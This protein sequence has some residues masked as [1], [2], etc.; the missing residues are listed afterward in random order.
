MER[1]VVGIDGS[2]GSRAALRWGAGEAAHHGVPL[3]AVESWEFSPLVVVTEAPVQLDDLRASV[4][5]HLA[6]VVAEELG[7]PL[8]EGLEVDR[9]VVEGVPASTLIELSGPET[10][11]V[12]GSRGRGGF[13]GLL[14]GSVS[15][16]VVS[17][18]DGPVAVIHPDQG[19]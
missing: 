5:E 17:H 6:S 4:V 13:T 10:L 14:L 15:Q 12:V 9:R 18:A 3:I 16:Q 11:V 1:V 8:P 19:T 2:E 7:D